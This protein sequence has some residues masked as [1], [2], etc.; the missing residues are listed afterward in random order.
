M[1]YCVPAASQETW[2]GEPVKRVRIPPKSRPQTADGKNSQKRRLTATSGST[3]RSFIALG[4]LFMVGARKQLGL[5]H[6]RDQPAQRDRHARSPFLWR[7]HIRS[8]WHEDL[9]AD[10]EE[11]DDESEA[12]EAGEGGSCGL[13]ECEGRGEEN[14]GEEERSPRDKISERSDEDKTVTRMRIFLVSRRL[15]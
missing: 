5:T 4:R 15:L 10:C 11:A 9:Y 3:V 8:E 2:F 13:A 1:A 6:A 7:R 14:K 12:F